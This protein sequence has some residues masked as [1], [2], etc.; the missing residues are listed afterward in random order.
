VWKWILGCIGF[1]KK[2]HICGILCIALP[3]SPDKMDTEVYF[4]FALLALL[5]IG[6]YFLMFRAKKGIM[7]YFIVLGFL[8]LV[9]MIHLN[10]LLN[11]PP[12]SG[13]EGIGEAAGY[14]IASF[15]EAGGLF[16]F[17]LI[18]FIVRRRGGKSGME[19]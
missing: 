1:G 11:L 16:L 5:I 18:W 8:L 7:A 6:A 14:A 17:S 12:A 13:F 3:Q 2:G 10:W 4:Y 9:N 19:K 15:L